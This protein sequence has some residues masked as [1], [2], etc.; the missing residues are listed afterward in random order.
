V[1]FV[2]L[3]NI[4]GNQYFYLVANQRTANGK[5][6]QKTIA[7]LGHSPTAARAVT[8]L[9]ARLAQLKKETRK[10]QL[11]I[12]GLSWFLPD[13]YWNRR[14]RPGRQRQLDRYHRAIQTLTQT[15]EK[16][17]LRSA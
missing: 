9:K 13:R 8:D 3:K 6:R 10:L 12:A 11:L 14:G 15:P 5:V 17:T 4:N 7:C 2:R 1:A 16:N